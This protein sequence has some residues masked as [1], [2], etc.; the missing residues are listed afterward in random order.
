ME[1]N[2]LPG[3]TLDIGYTGQFASRFTDQGV[4][5]H[6]TIRLSE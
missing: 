3:A 6:F 4:H 5:G 1:F 2:I